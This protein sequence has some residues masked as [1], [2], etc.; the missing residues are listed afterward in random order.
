QGYSNQG[1][2]NQGNGNQGYY[3]Q[4]TSTTTLSPEQADAQAEQY[5]DPFVLLAHVNEFTNIFPNGSQIIQNIMTNT[6]LSEAERVEKIAEW[7]N[8]LSNEDTN[9]EELE[10]F[11]TRFLNLSTEAST[12]AGNLMDQQSDGV[13]T[14]WQQLNSITASLMGQKITPATYQLQLNQIY[15][16]LSTDDQTSFKND[17][18]QVYGYD[19]TPST[20]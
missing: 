19:Y 1:Y 18:K 8:D 10:S 7:Y 13:L 17:F 6:S 20:E 11:R 5:M 9:Q 14:A 2:N 12:K 16:H 3:Q 15:N 4:S